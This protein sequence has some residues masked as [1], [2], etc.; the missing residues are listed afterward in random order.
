M[1]DITTTT[2]ARLRIRSALLFARVSQV[3]A[4]LEMRA[5]E[6]DSLIHD[7]QAREHRRAAFNA[8]DASC[9]RL[10]SAF[11]P[12]GG[13][14]LD[15]VALTG[16]LA[17]GVTGILL[18]NRIILA[19]PSDPSTVNHLKTL[20]RSPAGLGIR[21]WGV[22]SRWCWLKSLYLQE[23]ELFLASPAGQDPKAGWRRKAP[24]AKQTYLIAQICTDLQKDGQTFATRGEAFDWIREQGGNPKFKVEPAKP[25]LAELAEAFG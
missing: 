10:G 21:A 16:W 18:L 15:P 17:L 20:F 5:Q 22:W 1:D 24:T 7:A 6:L 19:T 23:T 9:Y 3:P 8:R 4:S 14:D 13:L 2:A 11:E 12:Q 25:D